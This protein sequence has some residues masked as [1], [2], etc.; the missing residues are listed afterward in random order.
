MNE[1]EQAI[2]L[3]GLLGYKFDDLENALK[4]LEENEVDNL[5][6]FYYELENYNIE[7][8][9]ATRISLA[10]SY[11]SLKIKNGDWWEIEGLMRKCEVSI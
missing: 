1:K 7:N 3:L 9:T 5:V 2:Y 10:G 4:L 6:D 11:P 8:E